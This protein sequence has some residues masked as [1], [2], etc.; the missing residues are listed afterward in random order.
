[1]LGSAAALACSGSKVVPGDAGL[2]AVAVEAGTCTLKHPPSGRIC[3]TVCYEAEPQGPTPMACEAYCDKDG[4]ACYNAMG[5]QLID[6]TLTPFD[7][8]EEHVLC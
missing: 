2:D 4:G 6:C 1:M 3:E 7:G 8:G 5:L